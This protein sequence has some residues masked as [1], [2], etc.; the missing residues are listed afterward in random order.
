MSA[1]HRRRRQSRRP[2]HQT[3][4]RPRRHLARNLPEHLR[5]RRAT[6][7]PRVRPRR[8]D[9]GPDRRPRRR[10]TAGVEPDA[11]D[12]GRWVHRQRLDR[13]QDHRPRPRRARRCSRR[14]RDDHRR[15]RVPHA[16]EA[17]HR[18]HRRMAR[19]RHRVQRNH[20]RIWGGDTEAEV[21]GGDRRSAS[22]LVEDSSVDLGNWVQQQSDA[23]LRA[24]L[25]DAI[26]RGTGADAMPL[27]LENYPDVHTQSSRRA[28]SPTTSGC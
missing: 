18:L 20:R 14:A 16:A 19:R 21:P 6:D 12:H 7:P 11:V 24:G 4:P 3:S 10:G 8:D 23:V 22:S 9:H 28:R 5:G 15:G 13:R 27:G 26:L 1:P 17:R 2:A 25:E